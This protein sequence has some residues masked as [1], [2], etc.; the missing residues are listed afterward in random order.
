MLRSSRNGKFTHRIAVIVGVASFVLDVIMV[1]VSLMLVLGHKADKA[2]LALLVALAL[3]SAAAF[4]MC[5]D[6]S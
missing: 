3:V 1:T 2:T 5:K 4:I 6:S